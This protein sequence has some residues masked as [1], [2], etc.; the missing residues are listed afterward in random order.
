MDM[1]YFNKNNRLLDK[2][3]ESNSRYIK[4]DDWIF[5]IKMVRALKVSEY[6]KPY[7][8]I[9]NC[10]INGDSLIIDGLLTKDGH[11]FSKKDFMTFH[12]FCQKLKI[13]TCSYH[14]FQNGESIT[15]E[16]DIAA[17]S[18]LQERKRTVFKDNLNENTI[19]LVK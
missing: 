13:S 4:I 15:K 5:E 10:N 7:E 8:A 11:E 6:G 12:K 14:R 17:F 18:Q 1:V 19:R 16:I 9:A 3:S 2:M